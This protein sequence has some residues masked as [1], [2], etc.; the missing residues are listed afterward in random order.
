MSTSSVT[1]SWREEPSV[2]GGGWADISV[3]I[4]G[5]MGSV[6]GPKWSAI[7]TASHYR[8]PPKRQSWAQD[9]QGSISVW[10]HTFYA[11]NI[12]IDSGQ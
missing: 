1:S 5:Q 2:N 7:S 3:K 4:P 12:D 11:T 10:V 8:A 9:T 6:E